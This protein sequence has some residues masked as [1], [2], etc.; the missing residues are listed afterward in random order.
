MAT[1]PSSE[2]SEPQMWLFENTV[3]NN[4]LLFGILPL[5]GCSLGWLRG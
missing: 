4:S 1:L 5:Q 2:V 3:D